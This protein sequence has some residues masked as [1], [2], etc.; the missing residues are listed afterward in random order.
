M[1]AVAGRNV[2][3]AMTGAASPPEVLEVWLAT[4][5]DA[6]DQARMSGIEEGLLNA[7][8]LLEDEYPLDA[9]AVRFPDEPPVAVLV[10]ARSGGKTT[11]AMARRLAGALT[12]MGSAGETITILDVRD[13]DLKAG[14][15]VVDREGSGPRCFGTEPAPGYGEPLTIEGTRDSVRLSRVVQDE[16]ARIAVVAR[17]GAGPKGMA[18]FV[19]DAA[20][21][22]FD[23]ATR[24]RAL[25]DPE[26]GARILS[27]PRI[28][29]KIRLVVGDLFD[30]QTGA[31]PNKIRAAAEKAPADP[32]LSPVWKA[33]E[34]L[35]GH[36]LFAVER[37]GHTL[38]SESCKARGLS[39]LGEHPIL[40]A[41]VALGIPGAALPGVSWKKVMQ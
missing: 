10:D 21:R 26:F 18:P 39:P 1:R 14:G 19:L 13:E 6:K 23:T 41:A 25:A 5:A 37:V 28:G 16:R 33:D 12:E 11:T 2:A 20:L 35:V 40:R 15:Y 29:G 24:Q 32:A 36:D 27:S 9:L 31:S 8:A 4:L 17:L 38:L 3:R 30:V 7:I 22:A 34:L